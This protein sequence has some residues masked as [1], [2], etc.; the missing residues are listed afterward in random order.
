MPTLVVVLGS[1]AVAGALL[2]G[3][4]WLAARVRRR[5]VGGSPLTALDEIWHPAAHQARTR[6]EIQDERVTPAPSPADP[7]RPPTQPKAPAP[8]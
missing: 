1:L 5:G 8:D 3:L 2:G 6:I 4:P 7:P